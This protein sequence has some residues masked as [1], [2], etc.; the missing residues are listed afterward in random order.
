[1]KPY[2]EHPIAVPRFCEANGFYTTKARSELMARI[3]ANG[4]KPE[5]ILRKTLWNLGFRYRKNVKQLPGKP[6]IVFRKYKLVIFIDGEFWHG[7]QWDTKKDKLKTNRGFWIPKI[8]RNMQ[9][10]AEITAFYEQTNWQE[11]R[12]W[13][14]EVK[15]ETG[16]CVTRILNYLQSIDEPYST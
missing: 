4:N 14:H 1:M 16:S 5:S 3:K 10:D 11:L 9:R 12:F 2:S 13:E 7:Y 6:D 15:K 8:E